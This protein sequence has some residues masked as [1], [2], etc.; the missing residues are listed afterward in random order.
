MRRG[1]RKDNSER[2]ERALR[3]AR[4]NQAW[5][6]IPCPFCE[7]A[8]HEDRKRSMGVNAA[9]GGFNCFRCGTSGKMLEPP[10]PEMGSADS[11]PTETPVV[12]FDPPA[13]FV[14]LGYGD[15]ATAMC[16][17]DA[18]S[19]L[20]GRGVARRSLVE[21]LEIGACDEGFWS[22]RILVPLLTSDHEGWLG[23]TSRLWVD[24]PSPKATGF[25]AM[26]Y[27][28]PKGMP[29]GMFLYNHD[30][31]N[32]ETD[33]PLL[34]VEGVFDALPL[35]PNAVAVLG[36]PS[37]MQVDAL[38]TA[39]RPIAVVLDGDA[40]VEGQMLA[41]RLRFDGKRAGHVHLAPGQDPDEIDREQLTALARACI[42]ADLF[43]SL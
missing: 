29:R 19:Y 21:R 31:L 35:W 38:L 33:E 20:K 17:Q 2:L 26:K 11:E 22:G 9:S 40:W 34:V 14:P 18:R 7:D 8:G 15:G 39:R 43:S 32:V 6:R 12:L 37:H 13:E 5:I 10:N 16:F 41:A 42:D 28:Y 1:N 23:W 25:H 36:K 24:K 4:L 30:A 27:L 3:G